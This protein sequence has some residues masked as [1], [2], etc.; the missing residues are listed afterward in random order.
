MDYRHKLPVCLLL[1]VMSAHAAEPPPDPLFASAE[2][3]EITLQ[4]PFDRIDDERDKEAE[5]EGS[6]SYLDAS[7]TQV[8][9]DASFQVRGNWRLNSRN[10]N[11]S[12]LWVDLRRGQ[13]PGTI[14]ENQNRLKLVVQCRRNERYADYLYKELLLYEMFSELA[15]YNFDTRL[16]SVNYQDTEREDELRT[17]PAFFIEHQNRLADRYGMSE[18]EENKVSYQAL[19]P[20]QSTLVDLFMYFMGNTDY[21]I[22]QGPE[23]DE[24]CHNSKLLQDAAGAYFP[25][26]YDFDASGFVDTS[27]APEPNPSFGLRNNRER[28]F[29]G[30]CVD[31]QVLQAAVARF[32]QLQDEILAR[33]NDS[34]LLSAR[35]IRVNGRF[36]EDFFDTLNDARDFQRRIVDRCRG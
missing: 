30:F 15:E 27:Y 13:L 25:I 31:E 14:F 19:N 4:G 7:G 34:P 3:L 10:C 29:R 6:L 32:N 28:L 22:I 1:A 11:Y 24:C 18:V 21:S 2:V 12:P 36:A 35:S 17:A 9:L 20:H 23:G 5:Y 33:I 26:P 16:L 8:V